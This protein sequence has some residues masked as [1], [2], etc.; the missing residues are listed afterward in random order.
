MI[1]TVHLTPDWRERLRG[2]GVTHPAASAA[3]RTALE[4]LASGLGIP[5]S[6]IVRI[7]DD[8][9]GGEFGVRAGW[10]LLRYPRDLPDRVLPADVPLEPGEALSRLVSAVAA[11]SP[12]HLLDDDG[13]AAYLGTVRA[14][15]D[16]VLLPPRDEVGQIL[17]GL[18]NRALSLA[19]SAAVGQGLLD[20]V[21]LGLAGEEIEE[22]LA[23]RL[24]PRHLDVEIHP[25]YA[26]ALF[27]H[28]LAAEPV[29]L[30]A[31]GGTVAERLTAVEEATFS[32]LGLR[33][34][35]VRLVCRDTL[36]P[37]SFAVRV[38]HLTGVPWLGLAPH[39]RF[40]NARKEQL[41]TWR[42]PH[43]PRAH[44]HAGVQCGVVNEEAAA[45]V[46]AQGAQLGD[47]LDYLFA[48]VLG[49][50]SRRAAQLIDVEQVE[51]ELALVALAYPEVVTAALERI[52]PAR[53][54]AVLRFLLGSKV[55]I[56]DLRTILE[57]VLKF[58][59]VVADTAYRVVLDDR[60]V[61]DERLAPVPVEQPAVIAR[62]VRKGLVRAISQR[63]AENGHVAVHKLDPVKIEGPLLHHLAFLTRDEGAPLSAEQLEQIH[64]AILNALTAD[65][66][67]RPT[68][69]AD[70]GLADFLREDLYAEL[71]NAMVV[72]YDD[73]VPDLE[74]HPTS[75][76]LE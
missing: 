26:R 22:T 35:P 67:S 52:S 23:A 71:P 59:Y 54:T 27:G 28:P 30:R 32:D 63:A 19:D 45:M 25:E 65:S 76:T 48:V 41:E 60:L 4:R 10:A 29:P 46:S 40:A 56:R 16:P 20:G 33:L 61:I 7:E 31:L 15:V 50:A 70:P 55:P 62:Y 9:P 44:P 57:Q 58:D 24:R 72:S 74:L 6:F 47:P 12:A 38:N 36:H 5:A 3:V 2:A 42:V 11:L 37:Q 13:V 14:E 8:V 64:A 75:I 17:R 66:S 53:L 1:V 69:L 51:Y 43:V 21:R 49:E 68:L 18:L 73:L 34:P 39:E